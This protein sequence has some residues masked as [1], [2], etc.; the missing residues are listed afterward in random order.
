[1]KIS[2]IRAAAALS[3]VACSLGAHAVDFGSNLIINGNAE[4]DVSGWTAFDGV[5]LFQSVDYGSNWVLPS[6]PGPVDRGSKMFA[7]QSSAFSVGYQLLDVSAL[8]TAF[9]KGTTAFDLSGYLGGWTSQGDNALLYVSF[10]DVANQEIGSA[11]L[12]PVT[13]ADRGNST[14]LLFRE[15]HGFVPVNTTQIQFALS[16]ERMA[17]NDNDGYADN[18]SFTVSAAPVPEP[19]TFAMLLAG[20]GLVGAIARRRNKTTSA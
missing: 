15:T 7:G 12:G 5:D 6:Q 14:G 1:M 2:L 13:P 19:E 4:A 11:Q 16:M 3:L 10:M 9:A 20:L 17:S 8:T 18:L